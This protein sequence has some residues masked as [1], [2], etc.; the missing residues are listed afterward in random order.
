LFRGAWQTTELGGYGNKFDETDNF[1]LVR[2]LD[3]RR[4]KTFMSSQRE[5]VVLY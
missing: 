3:L 1:I 4:V 2:A 5:P